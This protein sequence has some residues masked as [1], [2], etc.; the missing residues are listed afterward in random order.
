MPKPRRPGFGFFK[1]VIAELRKVVWPSRQEAVRLTILVLIISAVV[2]LALG[3][4]DL[5]FTQLVR[6]ILTGLR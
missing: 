2:G 6:T 5:G 3:A 4:V 1:E